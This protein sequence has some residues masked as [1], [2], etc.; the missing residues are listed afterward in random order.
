VSRP[1]D[2]IVVGAGIVGAACAYRLAQEGLMVTVVD[3]RGIA[4]GTTAAGMGHIAVMDGSDP[5]LALTLRSRALWQ[6]LSHHIPYEAGWN[7]CG[8][9]WVA[10]DVDEMEA[11][12]HRA[13]RMIAAG[14]ELVDAAHLAAVEP[15]LRLGLAG[16]ML[17]S[18]D[19]IVKPPLVAKWMLEQAQAR[20]IHAAPVKEVGRRKVTLENG[21]QLVAGVIVMA[22]GLWLR[23]LAGIPLLAKK[24]HLVSI[25]GPVGFCKHQ[26][27]ETGYLAGTH[28]DRESV[29]FNIQPRPGGELVV[30]SSRQPG[31]ETAEIEQGVVERMLRRAIEF[32]P[33]LESFRVSREWTGLRA[34]TPDGLPVIGKLSEGVYIAG[35]HEGLGLT[36]ALGTAELIADAVVG[37][38]S[39]VDAEPFSPRRFGGVRA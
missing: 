9:L 36:M 13:T 24:G 31:V 26:I 11:L 1:T 2:A 29:S 30:G 19:A 14:A 27:L 5:E 22:A 3:P 32:M 25:E 37:R 10:R 18:T 28:A 4:M 6:D 39:V 33:D 38:K 21:E 35:G 8:T 7:Q 20:M 34:A 23:K 17:V 16:G 12:T 15:R